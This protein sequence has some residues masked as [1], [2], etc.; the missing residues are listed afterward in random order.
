MFYN[1]FNYYAS[2]KNLVIS[3]YFLKIPF[4]HVFCSDIDK[5]V[6]QSIKANYK[7]EIIFGD[8]DGPFPNGDITKRKLKDVPDIDLYVCGFPCQPLVRQGTDRGL[9]IG[10][11]MYSLAV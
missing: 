5:Y 10:E 9:K 1:Y 8:K 7:P 4:T 2:S 11:E 6:I 3:W